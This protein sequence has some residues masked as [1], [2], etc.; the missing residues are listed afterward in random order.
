[1]API[2]ILIVDDEPEVREIFR[3]VLE[4]DGHQVEE[5]S[6]GEAA[7]EL[8]ADG[9]YDLILLDVK[10]P[11][12]SGV[13][14]LKEVRRRTPSPRVVM[15]TGVMDDDLYDLSIYSRDPAN[16]FLTK[17]CSL[18]SLKECVEKVLTEDTPFIRTPRDELRHAVTKVQQA[19]DQAR[20]SL[21][22][23]EV[24]S[25][26]AL[27][28]ALS[29]SLQYGGPF[30]GGLILHSP[31][32]AE[33]FLGLDGERLKG[34]RLFS[35]DA[36]VALAEAVRTRARTDLGL[37]LVLVSDLSPDGFELPVGTCFLALG[38]GRETRVTKRRFSGSRDEIWREAAYFALVEIRA[39][40]K[41]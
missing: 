9:A 40:L 15:V 41:P 8:L 25:G 14:V 12:I 27:G 4:E 38:D 7:L 34:A 32:S 11:G 18:S 2:R 21:A 5:A 13:E 6:T 23:V 37:A 24:L 19:L 22:I 26:G 39:H 30:R 29:A 36:A 3:S 35:S 1:M 17:P 10:L 31:E 28:Q 16:G 33:L 20:R